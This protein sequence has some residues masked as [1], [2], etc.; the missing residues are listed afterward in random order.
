MAEIKITLST[1][2]A[3]LRLLQHERQT[4]GALGAETLRLALAL[5]WESMQELSGYHQA[6]SAVLSERAKSAR[7]GHRIRDVRD[8]LQEAI[9]AFEHYEDLEAV[10]E[11]IVS[12]Q[13][14]K[15]Q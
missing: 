12:S 13:A 5:C 8:G 9:A 6:T 14:K 15:R 2:N 1:S 4:G 7:N 3:F 11:R 10:N